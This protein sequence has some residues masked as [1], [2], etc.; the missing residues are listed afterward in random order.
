MPTMRTGTHAHCRRERKEA[1][2]STF[3]HKSG[4]PNVTMR[5]R[6]SP[7]DQRRLSDVMLIVPSRQRANLP[8]QHHLR[9]PVSN[10]YRM[11]AVLSLQKSAPSPERLIR[12][13]LF[14]ILV[15]TG[16][17]FGLV[18][19]GGNYVQQVHPSQAPASHFHEAVGA[20]NSPMTLKGSKR[21]HDGTDARGIHLGD[22]GQIYQHLA[23]S[24]FNRRSWLSKKSFAGPIVAIPVR[25]TMTTSAV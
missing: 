2:R 5:P 25:S 12:R 11:L 20:S 4:S 13:L 17:G 1:K 16:N 3:I 9:R 22:V 21:S 18:F 6:V 15:E 8:A 14:R 7:M 24:V 23:G 19:N 10:R